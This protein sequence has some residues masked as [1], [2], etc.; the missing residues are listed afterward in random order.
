MN[1]FHFKF[2]IFLF[3]LFP[4]LV[5]ADLDD[6]R[7]QKILDVAAQIV[8]NQHQLKVMQALAEVRGIKVWYVGG[9]AC[10]ILDYA[11]I[12]VDSGEEVPEEVHFYDIFSTNQDVDLAAEF[13]NEER[14]SADLVEKT[15]E[16]R[17]VVQV[18]LPIKYRSKSKWDVLT[19]RFHNSRGYVGDSRIFRQNSD[20]YSY[21]L[22]SADL[23]RG[24]SQV[25]HAP[26]FDKNP[27]DNN[28]F[29]NAYL[30]RKISFYRKK[31]HSKSASY[32]AGKNPEIISALRILAKSARHGAS[33]DS[34]SMKNIQ[35]I[36]DETLALT[37]L[38]QREEMSDLD[39]IS[40]RIFSI[41]KSGLLAAKNPK[42]TLKLYERFKVALVLRKFGYT[43]K[44]SEIKDYEGLL[45]ILSR[46]SQSFHLRDY[47]PIPV[48][49]VSRIPDGS[50]FEGT[51]LLH[52][53][54]RPEV[55][56]Y[57]RE[58]GFGKFLSEIQI[59]LQQIGRSTN[60]EIGKNIFTIAERYSSAVESGELPSPVLPL[61]NFAEDIDGMW[62]CRDEAL[63]HHLILSEAGVSTIIHSTEEH[64]KVL[65]SIAESFFLNDE[66]VERLS[67]PSEYVQNFWVPEN[68]EYQ[69]IET[70]FSKK[71]FDL[72]LEGVRDGQLS[73]LHYSFSF[74]R[75][76]ILTDEDKKKLFLSEIYL[77]LVS[78]YRVQSV[79]WLFIST[80]F[81]G[82][83]LADS[84]NEVYRISS[85]SK[86]LETLYSRHDDMSELLDEI[87]DIDI[88]REESGFEYITPL[89]EGYEIFI[90]IKKSLT[91][92]GV[93]SKWSKSL[94]QELFFRTIMWKDTELRSDLLIA[95]SF[96]VSPLIDDGDLLYPVNFRAVSNDMIEAAKFYHN[97]HSKRFF[98]SKSPEEYLETSFEEAREI[99]KYDKSLHQQYQGL[100]FERI[101]EYMSY[102]ALQDRVDLIEAFIDNFPYFTASTRSDRIHFGEVITVLKKLNLEDFSSVLQ[103]LPGDA[104][105]VNFLELDIEDGSEGIVLE[106]A[107]LVFNFLGLDE[108]LVSK[109]SILSDREKNFV[110]K[111]FEA[112][113]KLETLSEKEEEIRRSVTMYVL[114]NISLL[115]NF[116]VSS[117]GYDGDFDLNRFTSRELV[118]VLNFISLRSNSESLYISISQRISVTLNVFLLLLERGDIEFI[119]SVNDSNPLLSVLMSISKLNSKSYAYLIQSIEK[120][121]DSEFGEVHE[122][123]DRELRFIVG[124]NVASLT[125]DDFYF[126]LSKADRD[127]GDG[128][129]VYSYLLDCPHF[130]RPEVFQRF[131]E[132]SYRIF[133]I[134]ERDRA[135]Y[136]P[137]HSK[138]S[139]ED[140]IKFIAHLV[141]KNSTLRELLLSSSILKAKNPE[142]KTFGELFENF[143]IEIPKSLTELDLLISK[144]GTVFSFGDD[145]GSDEG[146]KACAALLRD[147]S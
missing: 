84:L 2:F 29:Y 129:S 28:I 61:S 27:S 119:D 140:D 86:K 135:R 109:V 39:Y 101:A 56:I 104:Y 4:P 53:G 147:L 19:L 34:R 57:R 89:P 112:L 5:S 75:Q 91:E 98:E 146:K 9:T 95:L 49:R 76:H 13:I 145:V 88:S 23:A 69:V 62:D 71:S 52:G 46:T 114:S 78:D 80:L 137:D 48:D 64:T 132:I 128:L 24:E 70:D 100:D 106:K 26:S 96:V 7:A 15:L 87:K 83:P 45:N 8:E 16:F 38:P 31:T 18:T 79:Y 92:G 138:E 67:V 74:I 142:A 139:V 113:N 85:V 17:D 36:I 30:K 63:L 82:D 136:I 81:E 90:L 103:K 73:P 54:E 115:D 41:V 66:S 59:K 131:P 47:T 50:I 37:R 58:D 118:G 123:S 122:W 126:L 144:E 110:K 3:F 105:L 77:A 51:S 94:V 134:F 44:S 102:F 32:S 143:T 21:A 10:A 130:W 68:A 60:E 107:L 124:K 120:H 33:I 1:S 97:T 43:K 11:T 35:Q 65:F 25:R 40:S 108:R 121:F 22:L 6:P 116:F 12:L 93:G 55:V 125:I 42:A 111:L 117:A 20:T 133:E 141:K 72:I 99:F 14:L 127:V